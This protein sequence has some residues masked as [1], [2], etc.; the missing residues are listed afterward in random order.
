MRRYTI[1][2]VKKKTPKKNPGEDGPI[3]TT[4]LM[5]IGKTMLDMQVLRVTLNQDTMTY[6][7]LY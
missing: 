2:M 4:F 5:L 1:E 3:D 6:C 7:I